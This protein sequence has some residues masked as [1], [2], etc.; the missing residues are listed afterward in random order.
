MTAPI[1]SIR[2][3]RVEFESPKGTIKAINGIDL[4][5]NEGETFGIVG[6]SGCGKSVTTLAIMGLLPQNAR[7]VSGEIVFQGNNLVKL[8]QKEYENIRASKI[9]MVFQDPSATLDPLYRIGDQVSEPLRYHNTSVKGRDDALSKKDI[10]KKVI[11]LL[12][13]VRIPD[14]E[15]VVKYYPHQLSGGMK[16]RVM[17]ATAI[18]LDPAMLI[19]DEPT[20]ALDVTIQDEILSLLKEI[21]RMLNTT[22]LLITHDFGVV[23]QMCKRLAVMYAGRIAEV[24]TMEGILTNPLHPYTKALLKSVPTL[25]SEINQLVAISGVVPSLTSIPEGCNFHNRC[26][27]AMSI[28][29]RVDPVPIL[30]ESGSSVRCHLYDSNSSSDAQS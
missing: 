20:T 25:S 3:L 2:D 29:S 12:D 4:D 5:I 23:A 1:L 15:K 14:A 24:S 16:Q 9:G 19:L 13:L 26:A 30:H 10:Q 18:A 8:S 28:C 22:I 17:I 21:R 6:E 7:I 27:S 11:E